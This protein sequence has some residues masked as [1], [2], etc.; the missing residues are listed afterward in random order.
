MET[1]PQGRQ[2]IDSRIWVLRGQRVM[3]DAELARLYGVELRALNQAVKRNADR[4]PADV[5]LAGW[6]N[7]S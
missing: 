5:E 3:L 4:F 6:L 7:A 1:K 2:T